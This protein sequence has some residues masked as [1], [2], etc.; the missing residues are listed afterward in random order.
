MLEVE[1]NE[2]IERLEKKKS[3]FLR[4]RNLCAIAT[5]F[6][7][8]NFYNVLKNETPPI[9]FLFAMGTIIL[10]CLG[11]G[12]YGHLTIKKTDS[13]LSAYYSELKKLHESKHEED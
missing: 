5:V 1:L 6:L 3:A 9:W 8:Y 2:Q 12:I 13:E 11:I 4:N 10:S 7:G